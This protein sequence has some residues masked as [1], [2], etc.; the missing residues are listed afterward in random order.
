MEVILERKAGVIFSGDL[1]HPGKSV[2]EYFC[3]KW[4]GIEVF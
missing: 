4:G 2:H 1:I 3:W